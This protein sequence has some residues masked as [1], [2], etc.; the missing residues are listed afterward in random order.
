[1]HANRYLSLA[2]LLSMTLV[3]T[4][5]AQS[6]IRWTN[7]LHEAQQVAQRDGRLI[8]IHFYTNWCG[9]CRKLE[10]DVFPRTDVAAS[11]MKN[12]VPVLIDAEQFRDVAAHFQVDRFPTDIITDASG[13]VVYRTGTPQDP[14]RY[15]QLLDGVASDHRF[16]TPGYA[17]AQRGTGEDP[18]RFTRNAR[19]TYQ[20][21][22]Q[23]RQHQVSQPIHRG[24]QRLYGHS[25]QESM[26]SGP[27][28]YATGRGQESGTV[29]SQFARESEYGPRYAGQAPSDTQ[30]LVQTYTPAQTPRE[31]CN[32]HIA[33]PA[34][35]S[36]NDTRSQTPLYE[37]QGSSPTASDYGRPR[38]PSG[39]DRRSGWTGPPQYAERGTQPDNTSMDQRFANPGSSMTGGRER[40]ASTPVA[41]RSQE[42]PLALDGFCPVTL[43]AN[44][45]WQ[46]GDRQWGAVHR[47]RTYLFSSQRCQQVFMADPD[48]YSPMLS[49]YDP[50]RYIQHG[51]TVPGL[52]QHGMWLHGKMYLF[53]DEPSLERFR[54]S[55][56]FFAQKAHEIM[57]RAD[58]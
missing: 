37:G 2:V 23:G 4:A 7:N 48:R 45:K 5:F 17:M 29:P 28:D 34:G 56:D 21:A 53:A 54:R 18:S 26:P 13:R 50:V 47:G 16:A 58:R 22:N 52:R 41:P 36:R 44:E 25:Y 14:I 49:G 27:S 1:M 24:G 42:P 35:M 19:D 55:P 51:E 57:M 10:R 12:Y 39:L 31:T 40:F 15:I 32:P 38:Q 20:P 33:P 8:L 43:E 46:Q 30:P 3:S 11:M 9:P 6:G